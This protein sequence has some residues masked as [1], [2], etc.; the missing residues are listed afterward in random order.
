[1]GKS[2][3]TKGHNWE[4]ELA[5]RFREAMPGCDA[6]RGLSQARG[7]GAEEA[8]VV[9]PWFHIEAKVG[10]KPPVRAALEQAKADCAAEKTPIA[11]IKEDRKEPFVV[12]S[13]EA[14]LLLI[15]DLWRISRQGETNKTCSDCGCSEA[16]HYVDGLRYCAMCGKCK[17]FTAM[18]S[19]DSRNVDGARFSS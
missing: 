16:H 3:R 6:R 19:Q 18:P 15:G 11:V 1:M 8:D 5:K 7:G 12:L 17:G 2:Q 9:I 4:R 10:K 14:F 13:L